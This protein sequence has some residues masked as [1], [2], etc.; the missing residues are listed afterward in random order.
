[1]IAEVRYENP[2]LAAHPVVVGRVEGDE[3]SE[4]LLA[5][6]VILGEVARIQADLRAGRVEARRSPGRC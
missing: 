3:P 2:E 1:M 5:P 6:V 4:D